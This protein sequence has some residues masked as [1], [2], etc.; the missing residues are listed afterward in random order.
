MLEGG[1]EGESEKQREASVSPPHD[2]VDAAVV[3]FFS[4]VHA[5]PVRSLS[6]L[7]SHRADRERRY[8]CRQ[9]TKTEFE[10]RRSEHLERKDALSTTPLPRKKSIRAILLLL[11]EFA[12]SSRSSS[13]RRRGA[14]P[15]GPGTAAVASIS[16]GECAR[17]ERRRKKKRR[18]EERVF[19]SSSFFVLFFV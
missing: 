7:L 17:G 4:T 15:L 19:F 5:A 14:E 13:T 12:T 8:L 2:I 1:E 3:L 9:G 10:E 18:E 16:F 6:L 11:T